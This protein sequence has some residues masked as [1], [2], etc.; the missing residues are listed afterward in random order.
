VS[1][2]FSRPDERTLRD[3]ESSPSSLSNGARRHGG[4][5]MQGSGAVL[6][7]TASPRSGTGS[8]SGFGS[9]GSASR[10]A[11]KRSDAGYTTPPGSLT[12][13]DALIERERLASNVSPFTCM[14]VRMS[15]QCTVDTVSSSSCIV[16]NQI[17]YTH[18][19][20]HT[21]TYVALH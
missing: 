21:H 11:K 8:D 16:Q 19:H 13:G 17:S 2:G 15:V 4:G 14:S 3:H 10:G 9:S 12:T 5:G 20:T 6:K 18:T 1:F 7:G